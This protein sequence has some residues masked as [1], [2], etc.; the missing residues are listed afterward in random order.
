MFQEVEM[1][2]ANSHKY[3]NASNKFLNSRNKTFQI[4][5]NMFKILKRI[6]NS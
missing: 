2:K 4:C 3:N 1:L 6:K 5:Q